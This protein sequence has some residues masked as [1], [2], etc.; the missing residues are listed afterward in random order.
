M[1][2]LKPDESVVIVY[3][4][5]GASRS[6][7]HPVPGLRTMHPGTMGIC[8]FNGGVQTGPALST[9]ILHTTPLQ[10]LLI[11]IQR[12]ILNQWSRF[13]QDCV[14]SKVWK[15]ALFWSM[16]SVEQVTLRADRVTRCSIGYANVLTFS[17]ELRSET[18]LVGVLWK[19]RA[20]LQFLIRPK[21]SV[22][23]PHRQGEMSLITPM[24]G[25]ER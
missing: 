13:D 11:T 24:G 18:R 19:P 12:I 23:Q 7:P 16:S 2:V 8:S 1:V 9:W 20:M 5:P 25:E 10:L 14:I 21:C 6:Y 4:K 15:Q 3:L 22:C 17:E